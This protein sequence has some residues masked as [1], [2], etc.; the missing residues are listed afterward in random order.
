M[1]HMLCAGMSLLGVLL[2][3]WPVWITGMTFD[4]AMT[5]TASISS[6]DRDLCVGFVPLLRR[7]AS[8]VYV[9]PERRPPMLQDPVKL[10]V[11]RQDIMWKK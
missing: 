3:G 11:W 7:L 10:L 6:R 4:D 5:F 8:D 1:F 2:H 9:G